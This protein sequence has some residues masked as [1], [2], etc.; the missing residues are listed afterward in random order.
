MVITAAL[1]SLLKD[2]FIIDFRKMTLPKFS[3]QS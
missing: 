3:D 1:E 2:T